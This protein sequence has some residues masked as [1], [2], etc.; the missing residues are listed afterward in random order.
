MHYGDHCFYLSKLQCIIDSANTRYI[1]I[2]G[3]FNDDIK[4]TSVFGAELLDF[5]DNNLLTR[6]SC[7]LIL[8]HLL[9]KLMVLHLG[10]IIVLLHILVKL[11]RLIV[12]LLII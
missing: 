8:S 1:F 2:L 5:C 4:S 3:D 9:A 10:Y 7:Y 6:K 11:S 12:Q